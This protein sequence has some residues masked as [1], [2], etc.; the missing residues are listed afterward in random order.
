[1]VTD[2]STKLE[3]LVVYLLSEVARGKNS[4][5]HPYL[6]QLPR[7]YDIL[8]SFIDFES[9]A[10]QVEDAVQVAE[11][12]TAVVHQKWKEAQVLMNE[13]GL[14]HRF[15]NFKSW[16]WAFA[17][18]SSRTLHVPW[19]AAGCFCPVGDLFNYAAPGANWKVVDDSTLERETISSESS[20]ENNY[21]GRSHSS[22]H[23]ENI[24]E[25][26]EIE[27]K[28]WNDFN[29]RLTD[30]GYEAELDAYCFYAQKRYLQGE[31]VFLCYGVYTNLE[32]LEHYGF[33]LKDNPNDKI[34]I[35]LD[36]NM[37]TSRLWEKNHLY[38]QCDG[39]PSFSLLVALR[40][41]ATPPNL[42]KRIGHL[43]F[44]GLQIS[45]E[46]DIAVT[47]WLLGRCK[48]L[49]AKLPTT[50]EEDE[51]LLEII[52]KCD[53]DDGLQFISALFQDTEMRQN[54]DYCVLLNQFQ[55]W[56]R[57]HSEGWHN[58][59]VE[60]NT[61]FRIHC[62]QRNEC[63]DLSQKPEVKRSLDRWK[64]AIQWRLGY[65]T[66]LHRGILYCNFQL[67]YLYSSGKNRTE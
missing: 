59:T 66:I 53:E 34:Y 5:W 40:L 29:G 17:T 33:V 49:L 35:D 8:A 65:K 7:S 1:M 67:K 61:F 47:K 6:L 15:M 42:R 46:N 54:N 11:R 50:I 31:Q 43:A 58:V 38:L 56:S 63:I 12:A 20:N 62:L 25:A 2:V 26:P 21:Q 48:N 60:I 22:L 32:L 10:L 51:L 55:K 13:I 3:V 44:S 45:L 24:K 57:L 9:Q 28:G 23:Q 19:D 14:K 41:Y 16:L 36:E 18:V 39:K 4:L 30:G 27:N 64:L 37:L 52:D